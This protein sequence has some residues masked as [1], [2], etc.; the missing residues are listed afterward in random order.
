M[1]QQQNEQEE[2]LR[3]VGKIKSAHGIK[4]ELYLLIFSGDVSWLKKKLSLKLKN[5]T[6]QLSEFIVDSSKPHKDGAIVRL[7]GVDSRNLSEELVGCE[8]YLNKN[9]LKS[10]DHEPPYLVQIENFMVIDRTLGEIGR[11]ESFSTNGLQD[12]LQVPVLR[13]EKKYTVEIPFVD[14]FVLKIDYDNQRLEMDLP[15]GLLEVNYD[16]ED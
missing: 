14:Q 3:L 8:V 6:A 7:V 9:I 13:N 11:I 12:L 15:E 10:S 2:Q 4:G 5:K 16:S 1:K